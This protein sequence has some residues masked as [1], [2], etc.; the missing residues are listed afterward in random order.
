MVGDCEPSFF[1]ESGRGMVAGQGMG[2]TEQKSDGS[3]RD[4]VENRA[5]RV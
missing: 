3:R 5:G 1:N 2:Q 4:A